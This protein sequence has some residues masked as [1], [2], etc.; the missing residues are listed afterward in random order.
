M[1][2]T[3]PGIVG[4]VERQGILMVYP[5]AE[6]PEQSGTNSSRDQNDVL[7]GKLT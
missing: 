2:S 1:N 7:K 6:G 5:G 3:Q 4:S